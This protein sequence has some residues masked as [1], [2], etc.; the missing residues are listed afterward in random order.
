MNAFLI[1]SSPISNEVNERAIYWKES[2]KIAM[3]YFSE[4]NEIEK[5]S[6]KAYSKLTIQYNEVLQS[7]NQNQIFEKESFSQFIF[8]TLANMNKLLSGV[9]IYQ[10]E[11]K[12]KNDKLS[13]L[14]KIEK[15]NLLKEI[16][17]LKS[18]SSSYY[19]FWLYEQNLKFKIDCF[20]KVKTNY[21]NYLNENLAL[22]E[23]YE[24]EIKIKLKNY[25]FELISF[26]IKNCQVAIENCSELI[27]ELASVSFL[28]VH[29]TKA[30]AP[31]TSQF[32]IALEDTSFSVSGAIEMIYSSNEFNSNVNSKVL[33]SGI[34]LR[35][36]RLRASVWHPI[37]SVVTNEGF[38][39]LYDLTSTDIPIKLSL[40]TG[41]QPTELKNLNSLLSD[42]IFKNFDKLAH[43][44]LSIDLSQSVL[45][46]TSPSD[47]SFEISYQVS[48]F[49]GKTQKLFKLKAL[50]EEN[51]V[52]YFVCLKELVIETSKK[53]EQIEPSQG[54][55]EEQEISFEE[56]TDESSNP[57]KKIVE[58]P[59]SFKN[60]S[61][62]LND[63]DS[64]TSI[65][66]SPTVENND[67]IPELKSQNLSK[68]SIKNEVSA[69]S[70]QPNQSVSDLNPWK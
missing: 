1:D 5:I 34:L 23:K 66:I 9:R 14:L 11:F 25:F 47:F 63:E 57:V 65:D 68:M 56:S 54:Q 3:T 44:F 12:S 15:G 43:P 69:P 8:E 26:K 30:L 58:N 18:K 53:S 61:E 33:H 48:G 10:N 37:Y 6:I 70:A 55:S 62:Y 36:G 32:S 2:I 40:K 22:F 16:S 50:T 42:S 35:Q 41:L 51:M 52:D 24:N 39:H 28:T 20:L 19:D 4:I 59:E 46:P 60:E 67:S 64:L 31:S 45:S 7:F 27:Q 21:F 13:N 49:F 29:G 17:N 38:I